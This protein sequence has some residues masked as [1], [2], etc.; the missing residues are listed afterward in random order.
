MRRLVLLGLLGLGVSGCLI[1]PAEDDDI[2]P[3]EK[4]LCPELVVEPLSRPSN[5]ATLSTA[6]SA[7]SSTPNA[8][9]PML[10]RFRKQTGV[11]SAAALRQREDKVRKLGRLKYHW[12]S[13][14]TAALSLTSEEQAQLAQ[15]PDVLSITPDRTVHALGVSPRL[16]VPALLGATSTTGSPTEYTWAVQMT[17][18][19]KVWDDNNDGV[20]DTGAPNG[21][22]ITVCVIDSGIDPNHAELKAAYAGGRDFVDGDDTPDDKDSS[23]AWGGG[24][25]THVAGTILAQLG[26]GGQVNPNDP[27]LS[28]SGM[29]GLAPGARLLVARVLDERG[30]GRTSDV[31]EAL[32]WCRTAGANIVSLSLGSSSSDPAEEEAFQTSWAAGVLAIAASG[33]GGEIATPESKVYPAAYSTVIAVGAVDADKKHPK[34]SQGGEH[35][36]LV[37]PGVNIYSTYPTGRSPFAS[38]EA[39]GTFYT[40]GAFDYVPFAEYEGM[41]V[42]CGLGVGMRSCPGATCE[43]FVAYVDRGDITFNE[44]VRN[45]RS[46]GARAVIVGNNN[47]EDDDTLSF[48]LGNAATWPPVTAV[49]TT[50]VPIIRAQLGNTVR[51]GIRGG[52]YSYSTGTSMATPH[53]SAVAALVWSAN[54][55]LTNADVRRILESTAEDLV[56]SGAP[57]S[58][59][60][61][62]IVFGYGLVQAKAAVDQAIRERK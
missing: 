48:T 2:D 38:L 32:S 3:L 33:N 49:P 11:R 41:L 26:S 55:Q 12:S 7:L 59:E 50:T 34:F 1:D 22:G 52:D 43:G 30:D 39:G 29:V 18:A 13:L 60:G 28:P 42:D 46:Q 36:S 20:L 54:S 15:D 25:G 37:A 61:K 6:S 21:S 24:H 16:P 47:P 53:V 4:P 10:V 56:D 5:S 27:S 45:V 17:Q 62:D 14:D 51:V 40:S 35:L 31:I 57:E 19:N 58:H 9:Q 8:S 23:G 44:K